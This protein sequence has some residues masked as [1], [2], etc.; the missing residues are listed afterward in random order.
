MCLVLSSGWMK[1]YKGCLEIVIPYELTK[2]YNITGL[3]CI[4]P[5]VKQLKI[6]VILDPKEDKQETLEKKCRRGGPEECDDCEQY[7]PAD[8]LHH[9]DA[10]S[11]S[12]QLLLSN[13]WNGRSEQLS[14]VEDK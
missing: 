5:N 9:G 14:L 7:Y 4:N 6:E 1:A 11:I 8:W 3:G 10:A 2:I 13:L 12:Q